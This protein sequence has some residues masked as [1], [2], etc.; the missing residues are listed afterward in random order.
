M[1]LN[2]IDIAFWQALVYLRQSGSLVKFIFKKK[3]N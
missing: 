2:G 3:N 1:I